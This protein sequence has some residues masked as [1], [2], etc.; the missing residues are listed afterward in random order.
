MFDKKYIK[1]FDFVIPLVLFLLTVIGAVGIG[2]SMRPPTDGQEQGIIQLIA[3]FNLRHVNLHFLWFAAG[4]IIMVAVIAFDY[5]NFYDLSVY[6]YW[7]IIAALIY[8]DLAGDIAG[9]AQSWINFGAFSFQPSEFAKLSVIIALARLL[10]LKEDGIKSLWDLF[11]IAAQ[12]G[13]PLVLI[14]LQP[15]F[16]TAAVIF[17]ISFGMLYLGGLSYK[18]IL[19]ISTV[20]GAGLVTMW[21]TFLTDEQKSRILVFLNP[22]ADAM[23]SGY[24]VMQSITAIGSGRIF[25]K[26]I[27]DTNMLSQLDFIPAK[28]TDFIF[29]VTGEAFGFLA[30]ALV[31]VLYAILIL[32]CIM[33]ASTAR[34]KFGSML[35][36][37]VA[38]MIM[39]HVFVNIGMTM[40][41]V[42]VT[43]IPLPFMSYGGSSMLTF[44]IAFGLVLN[45]GMRRQKTM[46]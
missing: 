14:I 19:G 1:N 36:S 28:H 25:G 32:R 10:S 43:G 27:F 12:A 21:F 38:S 16:G 34:D 42:P 5:K 39:F 6:L 40:G 29:S 8:V 35:A 3:S 41:L 24:H 46:F 45:V 31:I 17:A 33:I 11:P 2:I 30:G 15:D 22:G 13:I 18:L 20:A 44:L 4:L 7:V 26:N 37:G 9:G 23:G